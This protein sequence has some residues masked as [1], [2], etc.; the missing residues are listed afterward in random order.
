MVRLEFPDTQGMLSPDTVIQPKEK[1]QEVMIH[2]R[3]LFGYGGK[4][5]DGFKGIS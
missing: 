4:L 5:F 3:T 1:R 2:R